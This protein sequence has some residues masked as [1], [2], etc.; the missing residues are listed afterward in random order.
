VSAL[1]PEVPAL[2]VE[3]RLAQL[4]A[5][6]AEAAEGEAPA[7][8]A[9]DED[10]GATPRCLG[11]TAA[12]E[13]CGM[14]RLKG[15]LFCYHHDPDRRAALEGERAG[16]ARAQDAARAAR[17][18]AREREAWAARLETPEQLVAF[19]AAV[20]RAT[21]DHRLDADQAQACLEGARLLAELLRAGRWERG[22]G[23]R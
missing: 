22:G 8:G 18:A 12:G 11:E 15:G 23:L 19:V 21:W 14:V 5:L 13:P 3:E 1:L 4:A 16:R 7:A 17:A 20:T 6:A 10:T 9:V 2:R